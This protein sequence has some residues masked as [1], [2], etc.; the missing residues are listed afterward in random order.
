MINPTHA[1][2]MVLY[3]V[4]ALSLEVKSPGTETG[5]SPSSSA[6][7]KITWSYTFTPT[8]ILNA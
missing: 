7:G 3:S 8:Y 1:S 2:G 6:E 4:G 5:H